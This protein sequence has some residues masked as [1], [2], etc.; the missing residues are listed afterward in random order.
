MSTYFYTFASGILSYYYP[1]MRDDGLDH[2][3]RLV[4]TRIKDR[5]LVPAVVSRQATGNPDVVRKFVKEH[6]TIR[7]DRL[8]K[9]AE[10]LE[11][12][13]YVGPERT[14][15]PISS[16]TTAAEPYV[17][18]ALSFDTGVDADGYVGVTIR[19]PEG[20]LRLLLTPELSKDLGASL[21]HRALQIEEQK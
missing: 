2:I 17:A 11:L 18:E 16:S 13:F 5:G 7:A 6:T 14:I 1:I 21:T 9:L 20:P 10:E 4:D 19:T 8:K 3:R 15:N 12:E